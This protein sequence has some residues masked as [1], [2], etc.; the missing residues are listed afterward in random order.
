MKKCY[1]YR[2]ISTEM[3]KTFECDKCD[4][5]AKRKQHIFLHQNFHHDDIRYKC[6]LCEKQFSTK[7]N[8]N[9]HIKVAHDG[10]KYTCDQCDSQ[11]SV[12]YNLKI[13]QQT[14]HDE[15]Y[16]LVNFVTSST[17]TNQPFLVT[18]NIYM[19]ELNI[20]VVFVIPRIQQKVC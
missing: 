1:N 3:A 7:G 8:L 9:V 15:G 2:I 19:K 10:I 16:I 4:Y 20:L 11:F 5:T 17:V 12:K 14:V 18:R 13:H 6:D